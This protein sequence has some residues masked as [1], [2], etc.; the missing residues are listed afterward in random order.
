MANIDDLVKEKFGNEAQHLVEMGC[1]EIKK[2][3]V[4]NWS[5]CEKGFKKIEKALKRGKV[6]LTPLVDTGFDRLNTI[7]QGTEGYEILKKARAFG[8]SFDEVRVAEFAYESI[9]NE[10]AEHLKAAERRLE[11]TLDPDRIIKKAYEVLAK[12][13]HDSSFSPRAIEA[14]AYAAAKGGQVDPSKLPG[15]ED[16]QKI[17]GELLTYRQGRVTALEC[18]KNFRSLGLQIVSEETI[19]KLGKVIELEK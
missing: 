6:D 14:L 16:A 19:A 11:L 10:G 13:C 9:I 18:M 3:Y 8:A 17:I 4:G 15:E 5:L 12:Y 1:Q 2:G 7:N